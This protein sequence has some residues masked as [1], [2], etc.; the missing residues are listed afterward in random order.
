MDYEQ[1]KQSE[2]LI[3]DKMVIYHN[4]LKCIDKIIEEP[5]VSYKEIVLTIGAIIKTTL[6]E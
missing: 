2:Q 5:N 4:A 6:E 3:R 1:V